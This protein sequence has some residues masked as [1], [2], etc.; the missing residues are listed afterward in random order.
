MG[1]NSSD[2][3]L[4]FIEGVEQYFQLNLCQTS[5]TPFIFQIKVTSSQDVL[6]SSTPESLE[7]DSEEENSRYKSTHFDLLATAF[8]GVHDTNVLSDFEP[9][10]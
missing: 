4:V 5:S 2:F 7:S 6:V 3:L 8:E 1:H 9:V 10:S